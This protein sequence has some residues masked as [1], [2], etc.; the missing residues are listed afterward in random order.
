MWMA[1]LSRGSRGCVCAVQVEN[2]PSSWANTRIR[3]CFGVLGVVGAQEVVRRRVLGAWSRRG[4]SGGSWGLRAAARWSG[5]WVEAVARG[6]SSGSASPFRTHRTLLP[7]SGSP[8]VRSLAVRCL[9]SGSGRRETGSRTASSGSAAS[10][11]T[12]SAGSDGFS[13]R[14]ARCVRSATHCSGL[15]GGRMRHPGVVRGE[16]GSG[17]LGSG[18]RGSARGPARG[19]GPGVERY[20]GVTVCPVGERGQRQRRRQCRVPGHS[21]WRGGMVSRLEL[22]IPGVFFDR[23]VPVVPYGM[24]GICRPP[25]HRSLSF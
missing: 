19:V 4:R 12:R 17:S 18:G 7:V 13:A 22:C 24:H 8:A 21:V 23:S 10:R 11:S 1:R 6:M 15:S 14:E 5:G 16:V 20:G 25:L 9:S 3:T 2:V